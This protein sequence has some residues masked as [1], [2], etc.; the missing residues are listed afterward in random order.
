MLQREREFAETFVRMQGLISKV[1]QLQGQYHR[2]QLWCN[3]QTAVERASMLWVDIFPFMVDMEGAKAD[4][5]EQLGEPLTFEQERV[6]MV[7]AL[8]R[9]LEEAFGDD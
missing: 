8:M 3:V 4:Y 6:A 1:A 5:A 9:G 7:V 2:Q